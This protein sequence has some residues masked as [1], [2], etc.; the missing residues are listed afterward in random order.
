M[1]VP[2]LGSPLFVLVPPLI[3]VPRLLLMSLGSAAFLHPAPVAPVRGAGHAKVF[4]V[5]RVPI[6]NGTT[7]VGSI[8]VAASDFDRNVGSI[9]VPSG[10]QGADS[11]QNRQAQYRFNFHSRGL[12]WVAEPLWP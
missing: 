5:R 9:T 11:S 3:P 4:A 7:V 12:S 6:V 10:E 2:G 8:V 1:L